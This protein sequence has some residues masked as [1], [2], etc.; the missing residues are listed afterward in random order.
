LLRELMLSRRSFRQLLFAGFILITLMLT[1]SSVQA[2]LTLER[3]ARLG[4][5]T[6]AQTV[7]LGEQSQHL[8][9]RTQAMERSARQFMV[10]DEAAFRER[11]FSAWEQAGTA[12]ALL[13]GAHAPAPALA[14]EWSVQ[15]ETAW[16]ALKAGKRQQRSGQAAL[17]RVFARLPLIN[18]QLAAA[19]KREV[20]RR[21]DAML[22][23]LERQRQWL[24]A[25]VAGAVVLSAILACWFGAWLSRPLRRIELAI[26]RLGE[27]RFD[28]VVTVD[29]PADLRRLGQQLDWLRQRLAEL[30]DDQH[31]FLRHVSHELKTPL[32]ALR[33][34]V[35]LLE[36]SVAGPLTA[37]QREI[38]G[39]LRHNSA[40][41]QTQIED[42]LRYHAAV[43]DARHVRRGRVDLLALLHQ[44]VDAQRLQWQARGLRVSVR[45]AAPHLL[46]DVD[47]LAVA[48]ANIL[49]NA[50]RFSP[51]GGS[52]ALVLGERRGVVGIDC[53]DDGPGV[54]PAD[55]LRIF[56]PFY[57]GSRRIAGARN[58]NGIGLSIVREYVR[59]HHGT[60]QLIPRPQGAHFR[61]ELPN[62]K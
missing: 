59:A 50:V 24:T 55:A 14:A 54:A 3:L 41:L 20:A 1:A 2:L 28:E 62:E 57:Q 32:A 10:L 48:L 13:A 27:G 44:V 7:M 21:N 46:A 29:G 47:Q 36:E 16:A 39:I 51:A 45:G 9:E 30:D 33:E 60:V 11:Y 19:N 53:I 43:F 8:A 4:R 17:E 26:G 12:L 56:E 38:T 18:E 15:A 52:I 37:G 49:S 25:L 5:D 58:G 6:A 22:T 42:L 35:A 34:G 31:R 61:I 40:A 23:E